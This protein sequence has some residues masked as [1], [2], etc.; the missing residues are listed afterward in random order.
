MFPRLVIDAGEDSEV[1]VS[2]ASSRADGS[3]PPRRARASR[4][5]PARRPG[6]RYLGIN[7][8]GDATWQIGHQQAVGGRDSTMLLATVALGG[9]YARVRTEA[10]VSGAGASTRQVALYFAGG[11]QMHDFRT[12]QD[13]DAP[14]TTSDLLFKG[15]VQ[16]RARS[17]Y[18]GL[19]RIRTH[20]RGTDAFQ[21][22]RNL[23]LGE[24]AWAE[25]VPNLEIET[26]DVRCSHASTVGPID[27][28][29][30][31]Y[32]ESRGIPTQRRRAPDRAR[33]LRRGARSASR[34]APSPPSCASGVVGQARPR[35]DADGGRLMTA[36]T[37]GCTGDRADAAARRP[38]ARYGAARRGRRGRRAP[39]C[40]STTTCTRSATSAATPTC[41]CRRARCGATSAEIECPKHGSTFSL[42]TGEPVTL[43]ATQPVPVFAT[44][45][46]VDGTVTSGGSGAMTTLEIRDLRAVGGKEILR[47]ID[48][49]VSSRRGARGDGPQRRRQEHL[50]GGRDGQARL[51]GPRRSVTLDGVDVLAMPTSERASAGLHLVLQYPIEV[52]GVALDDVM[53]EA[54]AARGAPVD[55]L[56]DAAGRGGGAHR[57]RGA[58]LHRSLNVDLSGGEK[59][60]N[61]TLQLAVLRPRIAML[62]ELDSGL[63]ID[64][65]R[66][67][68]RR[69]EALTQPV[70]GE[71]GL[72]VLAITHYNR[73]LAELRPDR[74]HILVR[75][76]IVDE[77]GP[78]LADRLEADGYAAFAADD[79]AAARRRATPLAIRPGSL[80]E[81][82][83]S[84]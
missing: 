62:D 14:H 31:F 17:V 19:I 53:R 56:D 12:I 68:A 76:R 58:L 64:A 83:A 11:D 34:P 82:F 8:L 13:H 51:R 25:S 60:R 37:D 65:L 48:L 50:V 30:R 29:Q 79:A 71:P 74:V 32:L 40:A 2:S 42:R 27:P 9:D 28:E 70:D 4:C 26:N 72:G 67:C 36:N 24:Q 69:I 73:L 21:T 44:D 47:G 35:P 33:L 39:W 3:S 59:K 5:A 63:D 7:E 18:T 6:S 61:E 55:G 45:V 49:T 41:R 66:A 38:R 1:T 52:P 10:R 75:G 43:P 20:A 54:L 23:T 57:A 15:A 84:G 46:V 81:L 16:D 80:D 77:G 78:E 22:N